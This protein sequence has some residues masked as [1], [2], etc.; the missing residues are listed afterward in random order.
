MLSSLGT[1]SWEAAVALLVAVGTAIYV[2]GQVHQATKQNKSDIDVIRQT[3]LEEQEGTRELIR[4]NQEAVLELIGKNMSDMKSML[5]VQKEYQR[6]SLNREI[7]HIKD[8]IS[9]SNNEM[10]EDI[11]RLEAAQK[12]SNM[13][14]ERLAIAESSLKS[15]HHRLDLE[16]PVLKKVMEEPGE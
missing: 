15:L 13:I 5:E 3:L 6:D 7:S 2:A 14:K 16:P 10:R 8:L 12:S 11:K 9:I 1:V 4:R